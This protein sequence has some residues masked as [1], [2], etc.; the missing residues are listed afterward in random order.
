VGGSFNLTQ[1]L[2]NTPKIHPKKSSR[3]PST[4]PLNSL[5]RPAPLRHTQHNT[6][7]H[8]TAQH[9][10][11]Q[12]STTQHEHSLGQEEAH[13]RVHHPDRRVRPHGHH[14]LDGR[15]GGQRAVAAQ[16]VVA[17]PVERQGAAGEGQGGDGHPHGGLGGG[18]G[19]G[20]G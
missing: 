6:A 20:W 1:H 12:H 14:A 11:A 18:G 16:Q 15:T 17:V 8:S 19:V 7:Q 10:T 2:N 9:N 5:C 13:R 4:S 3:K